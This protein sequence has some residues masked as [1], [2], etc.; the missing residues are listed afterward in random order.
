[1]SVPYF[2]VVSQHEA[3][4]EDGGHEASLR[5]QLCQEVGCHGLA[6]HDEIGH[7]DHLF[8]LAP[9]SP[10]SQRYEWSESVVPPLQWPARDRLDHRRERSVP[11]DH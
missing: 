9:V 10:G 8:R 2:S 7:I 1:M 3:P 4:F 6:I 11:I 5:T